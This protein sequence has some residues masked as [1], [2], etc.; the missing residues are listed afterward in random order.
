MDIERDNPKGIK[1]A[2]QSLLKDYK[3]DSKYLAT[4]IRISWEKMM[5]KPIASRTTSITLYNGKLKVKVNSAPLKNE[6]NMSR[7]KILDRIESEFGKGIVKEIVF[8]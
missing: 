1:D 4:R 2:F 6:L 5:G 7:S 3:I 8:I